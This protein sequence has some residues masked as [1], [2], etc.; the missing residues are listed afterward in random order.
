MSAVSGGYLIYMPT[1]RITKTQEKII[2]TDYV[3]I[4]FVFLDRKPQEVIEKITEALANNQVE[5]ACKLL[6]IFPQEIKNEI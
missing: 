3:E 5:I 6:D 2:P 1:A 4:V